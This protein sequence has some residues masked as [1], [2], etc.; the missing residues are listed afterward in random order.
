MSIFTA[1]QKAYIDNAIAAVKALATGGGGGTVGPTTG[2]TGLTSYTL[3][4]LLYASATNV[5]ARLA[6]NATTTQKV[7]A[8]TGDGTNSA[9]P[10]WVDLSTLYL[11]LTGGTM[12]G[13]IAMG[14]NAVTGAKT[15]LQSISGAQSVTTSFADGYVASDSSGATWTLPNNGTVGQT[16]LVIQGNTGQI[17]FSAG[18][19][20]TVY[21]SASATHTKTARQGAAVSVICISNS[22]G[23]A[24]V[25]IVAGATA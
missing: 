9:A 13:S 24:A 6:G 11:R 15:S 4:D 8:Q 1:K 3:G 19:G 18:M 14:G 25:W 20:A 2:G 10:S 7:L 12:S 17:T 21:F 23:S 22:G 16:F 5:L